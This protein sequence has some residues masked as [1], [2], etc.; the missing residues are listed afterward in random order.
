[1]HL[2]GNLLCMTS[3]PPPPHP[4]M[5][6]EMQRLKLRAYEAKREPQD[7]RKSAWLAMG[8]RCFLIR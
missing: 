7:Q 3:D 1:M 8:E 2:N 4:T 5:Q 6:I